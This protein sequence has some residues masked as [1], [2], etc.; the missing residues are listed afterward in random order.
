MFQFYLSLHSVC[1]SIFFFIYKRI[2]IIQAMNVS[3]ARKKSRELTWT[4]RRYIYYGKYLFGNRKTVIKKAILRIFYIF[5]CVCLYANTRT[6]SFHFEI[7]QKILF[8]SISW[9]VVGIT[10]ILYEI[11]VNSMRFDWTHFL[12][13]SIN[14]AMMAVNFRRN[15]D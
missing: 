9:C 12:N 8:Y 14:G 4:R 7:M 13:A 3:F 6:L 1:V 11:Y 5:Q 10:N 15:C 2:R